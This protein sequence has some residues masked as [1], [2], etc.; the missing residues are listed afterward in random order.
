L[1]VQRPGT[2]IPASMLDR[3][4]GR[5]VRRALVGGTMLTWDML[6]DAA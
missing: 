6:T 1:I 3:A 2:G 5:R 4:V